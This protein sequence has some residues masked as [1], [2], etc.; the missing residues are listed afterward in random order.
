MPTIIQN[1]GV[2]FSHYRPQV[3]LL[4]IKFLKISLS[5]LV[6]MIVW[7]LELQSEFFQQEYS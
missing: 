7:F 2:D 3:N 4:G 5:W 1:L 6:F